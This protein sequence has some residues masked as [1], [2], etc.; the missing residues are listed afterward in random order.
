M[1]RAA[2]K[3]LTAPAPEPKPKRKSR[4][5]TEEGCP[6]VMQQIPA[7]RPAARGR[8]AGF[9]LTTRAERKAEFTAAADFVSKAVD[10]FTRI[11]ADLY[12]PPADMRL[13]SN[14]LDKLNPYWP[15]SSFE[16]EIDIDPAPQ[17][18]HPFPR[19]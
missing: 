12:A 14:P 10:A 19:L 13:D 9:R 3:A 6:P 16:A 1:F 11:F 18:D 4:G 7:D 17:Q 5:G 8:Y 2:V 15:S